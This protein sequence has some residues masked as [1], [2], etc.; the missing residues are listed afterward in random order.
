MGEFPYSKWVTIFDQLNEVV[1]GSPPKLP[2]GKGFS[3][4]FMEVVELW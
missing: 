3:P 2:R 1:N 4:E